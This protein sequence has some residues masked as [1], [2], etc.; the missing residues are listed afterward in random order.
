MGRRRQAR[1]LALQALYLADAARMSGEEALLIVRA[2]SEVDEKAETFARQLT[3]GTLSDLADLDERIAKVA[4]N[5]DLGRMAAVDR[6]ILRMA[7]YELL[8]CPETPISVV[9]DE[10]LEIA[11][12][13]SSE[14]SSAFI[15]G[16]LDKVKACRDGKEP[17]S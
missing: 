17:S 2:G 14:D 6:N 15:N 12:A 11:K 13:Y 5:W 8:R 3:L 10:A 4:K 9:I 1:E 16:I 7:S